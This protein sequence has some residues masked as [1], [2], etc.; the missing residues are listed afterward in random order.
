M[1]NHW[2][3]LRYAPVL[4]LLAGCVTTKTVVIKTVPESAKVLVNSAEIGTSPVT[5]K[6]TFASGTQVFEVVARRPGYQD[7]SIQLSLED[8]KTREHTVHLGR[9]Q[10]TIRLQSEP[11][12]ATV[13]LNGQPA[14]ITPLTKELVF[15][16]A[17]QPFE[18]TLRKEGFK[19][20]LTN[21]AYAPLSR[22]DY[23]VKL[24]KVEAIPM[25]LISV[26]PQHTD[27]GVKLVLTRKPT[28]AYLE[29]I[30]RSP[31]VASV[32]RVTAN[33][34]K[35]LNIGPPVMSPAEGVVLFAEIVEEENKSWYS[36]IQ[37]QRVGELGKTR[38]TYGKW[39]DMFP[40]FTPDGKKAIFSS[41]RTSSNP[42]LWQV[43]VDIQIGLTKL[44]YTQ[45]EDYSPSVAPGDKM[46]VFASNP[47]GADEPQIWIFSRDSNLLTQLREGE[48]PQVS[49]DSK[50]IM[51]IRQDKLSKRH[52]LWVMSSDGAEETQLSQNTD[53]D[54]MDPR[55]S[56]DGKWI[57]Y[58]SN[59][60][61]DSQKLRNFDVWMMSSNGSK[62]T[63]LTTNG[64]QDD[65]PCW[66][67]E[68]KT[69][70]FRSNRGGAWNIWRF[71]PILSGE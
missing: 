3:G 71:Q 50:R 8:A 17:N 48:S 46:V 25:E 23:T 6:L 69:I 1:Q 18:V 39:H 51:F 68:G 54:I 47:P 20:A 14:G 37:K 11:V 59:E 10:K 15:D 24:D 62:R 2:K 40:A 35:D 27:T 22:T 33:E 49:P 36:N 32:T 30:E 53:Y 16:D 61:F 5:N 41:N 64:S 13:F 12:G 44:T 58:A 28:L 63:Q 31:N 45:A 7:G 21:L 52:Q 38:L 43:G 66:D 65:S 55:W 42:T 4:M 9:A 34:D 67:Y 26:E 56:P 57:V 29:V 60:G 19:D 70:Y